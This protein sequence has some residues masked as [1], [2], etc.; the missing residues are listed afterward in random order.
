VRYHR[1]NENA[2]KKQRLKLK[3]E[4]VAPFEFPFESVASQNIPDGQLFTE[5]YTTPLSNHSNNSGQFQAP[6]G[7]NTMSPFALRADQLNGNEHPFSFPTDEEKQSWNHIGNE[8]TGQSFFPHDI[9]HSQQQQLNQH[10]QQ[11]QPQGHQ[12]PTNGTTNLLN[13]AFNEMVRDQR[14]I[15]IDAIDGLI[16]EL[17][18]MEDAFGIEFEENL[19]VQDN[20]SLL[21]LPV[22]SESIKVRSTSSHQKQ[23]QVNPSS[24]YSGSHPRQKYHVPD[25]EGHSTPGDYN[26]DNLFL[27]FDDDE[28]VLREMKI[29]LPTQNVPPCCSTTN[30]EEAISI[31]KEVKITNPSTVAIITIPSTTLHQQQQ[32]QVMKLYQ[33]FLAWHYVVTQCEL[34]KKRR[35]NVFKRKI[36]YVISYH[37][38]VTQV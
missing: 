20:N 29:Y 19:N 2:S 26:S 18:S 17:G 24:G 30:K 33:K 15:D 11:Q 23:H 38:Q 10:K 31:P 8:V 4:G 6:C 16:A 7:V 3:P 13:P 27:S 37:H 1:I 5:I 22:A 34:K 35:T 21:V 25:L 36:R 14:V 12:Q 32:R 28:D 9:L